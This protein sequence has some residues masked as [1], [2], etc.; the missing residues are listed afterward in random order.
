[1]K[2]FTNYFN[3]SDHEKDMKNF[4]NMALILAL[5]T[6]T[7][8]AYAS[9]ITTIYTTGD[10]LTAATLD[11]IKSAVN[12][13][14][15]RIDT[16]ATTPGPTG[17]TGPQGQAGITGSQ[18]IVGATGSQGDTGSTGSQGDTGAT[19]SQGDTG[20]TGSQGDTGATGSQGDTGSTGSQGD[21]GSTGSQGGTGATGSKGDTGLTGPQGIGGATGSQGG[22]GATGSQGDTGATGPQGDTGLTGSQGIAGATGSQ[23]DTGLTGPQ[24]EAAAGPYFVARP[25]NSFDDFNDPYPVGTI[26]VDT[27]SSGSDIYISIDSSGSSAI[28]KQISL[29]MYALGDTGPGGGLVFYVTADGMHG[30]EVTIADLSTTS[31][32]GCNS[33]DITRAKSTA[34]GM[35]PINTV[36]ILHACTDAVPAQ[37]MAGH[38]ANGFYDWFLPSKDE[39]NQIFCVFGSYGG[40]TGVAVPSFCSGLP[41]A[42]HSFGVNTSVY[43]S[44]SQSS[45]TTVWGLSFNGGSSL[46]YNKVNAYNARAVREF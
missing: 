9:E 42:A 22:T 37:V 39:L 24:G 46:E 35:G 18:G 34:I 14:N 32:W 30:L 28:W 29:P 26:W 21:T 45:G 40:T 10:V 17:P 19:G 36:E 12:D 11:T 6:V 41:L 4:L 16:I 33:Q 7:H 20:S 25:P 3:G 5:T 23:G 38:T 31:G 2:A 44:S 1:M 27:S 15:T 8:T 13:N 43:W